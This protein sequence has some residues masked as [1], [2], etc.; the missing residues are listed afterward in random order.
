MPKYDDIEVQ[1]A[2]QDGNA[3]MILGRVSGAISRTYG[4]EA[5]TEYTNE[6]MAGDYDNLLRVTAEYVHIY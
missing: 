5:A 1:L 3:F 2:G 6:A 4:K